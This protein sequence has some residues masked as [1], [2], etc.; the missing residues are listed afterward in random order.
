MTVLN[1]FTFQA[2]K[3][4]MGNSVIQ[5]NHE[6]VDGS[7]NNYFVAASKGLLKIMVSSTKPTDFWIGNANY[8]SRVSIQTGVGD[9]MF[10][11]STFDSVPGDAKANGPIIYGINSAVKR[12]WVIS[13]T[14][15]QDYGIAFAWN[16]A[17]E[18]PKL[19]DTAVLSSYQSIMQNW[20]AVGGSPISGDNSAMRSTGMMPLSITGTMSVAAPGTNYDYPGAFHGLNN[21]SENQ[22][23]STPPSIAVNVPP[24]E[25]EYSFDQMQT[26]LAGTP[27]GNP[28]NVFI[29]ATGT[30]IGGEYANEA[31]TIES[32][33]GTV[34][35][36]P[37]GES[38]V[39]T[40]WNYKDELD[41]PTEE[42]MSN[43]PDP[44]EAIDQQLEDF[45]TEL[46]DG[47]THEKHSAF[48]SP[49][50]LLLE[51]WLAS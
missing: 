29:P 32:S 6:L 45:F 27:L 34:Y 41:A 21:S 31:L 18:G 37:N 28:L 7:M 12:T 43:V 11:V 10:G 5:I 39:N 38:G 25:G 36:T 48:K 2:G 9:T 16:R 35:G 46:A 8:A 4:N 24:S 22:N 14:S 3:F 23:F 26:R 42:Q 20:K 15:Q 33:G 40:N 50:D 49:I 51:E 17:E 44:G 13:S 47:S 30:N 19:G 1:D